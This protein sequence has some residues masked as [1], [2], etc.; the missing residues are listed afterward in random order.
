MKELN[1]VSDFFTDLMNKIE[2]PKV[3]VDDLRKAKSDKR[4]YRYLQL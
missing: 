3:K 4:D 1:H 2:G